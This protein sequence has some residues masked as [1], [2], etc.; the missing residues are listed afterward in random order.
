MDRD[1]VHENSI[2][3]GGKKTV[4]VDWSDEKFISEQM[5]E[6]YLFAVQEGK[7]NPDLHK[8]YGIHTTFEEFLQDSLH[9]LSMRKGELDEELAQGYIDHRIYN[10][11]KDLIEI[12]I[13]SIRKYLEKSE[14]S[15]LLSV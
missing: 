10:N 2:W 6:A 11:G 14:Q 7:K 3:L 4:T 9:R 5:Y 12:S 1:R 13:G 8:T 15:K